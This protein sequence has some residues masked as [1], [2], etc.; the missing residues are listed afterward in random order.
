MPAVRTTV[1]HFSV[2]ALGLLFAV[3]ST[4]QRITS[5]I[6]GTV[7]DPSGAVIV[8]ASVTAIRTE[9]GEQRSVT[10]DQAGNYRIPGISSGIYEVRFEHAGFATAVLT[11]IDILVNQQ[12]ILDS[13]L[14]VE[15]PFTL[16]V[17]VVAHASL[18]ESANAGLSGV[19]TSSVLHDLPL[20]GRDLFQLTLLEAGVL[21]VTSAGPNP[22]AD[23][24]S[25]KAAV[26]GARPT[27]NNV[28]LDGADINDPAYNIA[29]G[30][31]AGVQLGVEAIQEFRVLLNNYSAEFGRNAGA[32]VQNITRSGGNEFHGSLFEFHRNAALDARNFFDLGPIPPF[33]RNQFGAAIGGPI[34][35]NRTFFFTNFESL[36]ESRSVTTSLSVP[37]QNARRGLLP[38]AADANSLVNVGVDP[39]IAPFLSLYPLPNAGP[40][41]GGLASL[42][43][44]RKQPTTENYGL[45]RIDELLGV[46]DRIFARYVFDD[47]DST[48]PF[49][50]TTTPGFPS[51]RQIRNQY[52]ML[53][54]LRVV[55]PSLLNEAK[56]NFSRVRLSTRESYSYPLSISLSPNRALGA[57]SISGLPQLGSSLVS[58]VASASNTFEVIDNLSHER[59]GHSIK[60]GGDLKRILVNGPYDA[61]VNGSYIFTDL[62]SF[63][64]PAQS[65]N[66]A[67]EFFLK[68]IPLVYL[69]AYP[70]LADSNRG[71][72]QTY[73]GLYAQ[74]DWR[75]RSGLTLNFGFR[76][77]YWSNPSEA[78]GRLANIRNVL[79][80]TAP[81]AGKVWAG[82]PLDQWSPRLGFAWKPAG[83]TVVRGGAG[84]MRDQLWTNLYATTRFYEPYFRALQYILP[85][86]QA[87]P[88]D[89]QSLIGFAGPPSVIGIFGITYRPDFPYYLQYNVNVQREL[90]GDFRLQAAYVGS[91]GIHLVRTGEAN[92]LTPSLNRRTNPNFGSLVLMATD[93]QSFYNSGQLSLLRRFS[94]GLSME[95][96]YT[97]SKSIDDQ[98]GTFPS[99]YTSESGVA[100]NFYDRKGD[101]ARSSFDRTH[102]F[103]LNYLYELPFFRGRPG[104][105]GW[106]IGGVL[107]LLSG[108]P[109]TANLGSFNNSLTQSLVSADR[110]DLKP[111]AK[112]C[113]AN[114][115]DPN[116]WFDPAIFTLPA[117]G[118]F[119]NA[120]RNIMC[121]PALKNLDF[122]LTKQTKL[123][124]E[125]KLQFRAEFFNLLN[126]P[127]FDSPVNTQGPTGGGGNGD[128]VF[129][130]RSG[131]SCRPDTDT[132]RCGVLASNVAR[133]ARTVTTSRQIQFGLKLTF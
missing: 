29:P 18:L 13:T 6:L 73:A 104:A 1:R 9:T 77:E 98:S 30:G 124:E 80:D 5:D 42:Q 60:T 123:T 108:A 130:G 76:W 64:F 74:D 113:A 26:Q 110:P 15:T 67:F 131:P 82:V 79:T 2:I 114:S 20:N 34:R 89:A 21:P 16:T 49:A 125:V 27:M 54:W 61:L 118:T 93:A 88:N 69:G 8:G 68:G 65:N 109:F 92:P 117:P 48:V 121:G 112:P 133:I 55:R 31:V 17:D 122:S 4:A 32:N 43:T 126:H 22:F 52:L 58:P 44:S 56:V 94:D 78:H 57:V 103:V 7:T 119:G 120:G 36:R 14:P 12:A 96:S 35:K 107:T 95:A 75:V 111:S 24:G 37:D 46:R 53:N 10:T 71:F 105:G 132:F 62:T 81:A 84:I 41:G 72:R 51:N 106:G 86:F 100:Q 47:S 3:P 99:D 66:P 23:G 70:T 115:G 39:R 87:P 129:I 19:V 128:A 11:G 28:T 102:A 101:R 40:V 90:P 33:V 59:S 83:K 38:S 50:N 25:S 85:D 45:L 127:N 91:R 63:G 116:H 97:Y